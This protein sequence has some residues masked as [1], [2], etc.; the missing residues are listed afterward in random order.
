MK[1]S[2]RSPL[3]KHSD[4][5]VIDADRHVME[6]WSI[7]S[8]YCDPA[9]RPL[10]YQRAA[11]PDGSG[12]ISIAGRMTQFSDALWDDPYANRMFADGRFSPNK[13]L[14]EGLDPRGYLAAMDSEGIDAAI[15][16][17]TLAMGSCAAPDGRIGSALCRAY[18]RWISEF[19]S[20]APDRMRPVFPVNLHDVD[21]AIQ[22]CTWALEQFDFAGLFLVPLPVRGRR[23]HHPDFDPFWERV[24]DWGKPV[25]FHTLSSL[26]DAEG[27]GPLVDLIPTAPQFGANLFFHHMISHR[28]EQHLALASMV[29]GGVLE[30]NPKLCVIFTEAGGSWVQSWLDYMDEHF[31][32]DQMRR[33]VPW[34]KSRP[35]EYFSRQC[36]VSFHPTETV[37]ESVGGS[38]SA[39]AICW[40]SDYPHYDSVFP[41]AVRKMAANSSGLS[42]ADR[43]RLL[44]GN[45]ARRFAITPARSGEEAERAV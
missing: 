7:F 4:D 29:G 28:I 31:D 23:L 1:H 45:L 27:R 30:K 22:D 14:S 34:L 15:M 5:L 41:D 21:Q 36:L 42:T 33:H 3:G 17:P 44:G 18:A 24:N 25:V 11:L 20:I 2:G 35:S 38:L 19:C 37:S 26:P 10:V 9:V 39:E 6:T 13:P 16:T 8:Q 32:S 43:R 12:G 40:S